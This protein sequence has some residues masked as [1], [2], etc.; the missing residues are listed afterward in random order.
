MPSSSQSVQGRAFQDSRRDSIFALR[1][2][3]DSSHRVTTPSFF[4]PDAKGKP[5]IFLADQNNDV[6][7]IDLQADKNH[8]VGQITGLHT[9]FS[10][11]ADASKNL[12]IGEAPTAPSEKAD[13]LVYAPPYTGAPKLTLDDAN[14]EPSDISVSPKGVVAVANS[15]AQNASGCIPNSGNVTFY[16]K[17]SNTACAV[18]AAPATFGSVDYNAFADNGT[19]YVTGGAGTPSSLVFEV[20]EIKGGCKAKKI[21]VLAQSTSI[22]YSPI[23]INK[24]NQIAIIEYGCCPPGVLY[25]YDPPNT[26]PSE[27]PFRAPL[28]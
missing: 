15:C 26:A 7:D 23:R 17:N 4:N 16:P 18:I 11:A 9:P 20:G 19:L 27:A 25:T 10:L 28:W 22:L 12:Y 1:R 21:T 3:T 14:Y 5:L 2:G 6:V 13:V 8:M 24:A